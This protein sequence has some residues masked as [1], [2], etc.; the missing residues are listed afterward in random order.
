MEPSLRIQMVFEL[1]LDA[2]YPAETTAARRSCQQREA[3]MTSSE[4]R[5]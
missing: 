4:S 5:S 3:T 1:Q 2:V